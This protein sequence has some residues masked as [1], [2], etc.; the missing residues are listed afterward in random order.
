MSERLQVL[1]ESVEHLGDVAS[2]ITPSD[3]TAAAYPSEW[4]IADTF[5]HLGSGA[6]IGER[7]FEDSI[8]ERESDPAFN[9]SVWDEWNAK[10]PQAQVK[11]A[12]ASD[13]AFLSA[14][15]AASEEQRESFH[16][17]MGPFAF[18]FEGLVGLRLSEHALHTWDV[19]VTLNPDAT[20]PNN[21][22]NAILDGIQFIVARTGKA[23]S[24]AKDV[25]VRTIEPARDF[26]LVL[27]VD[28]VDIV[29][30]RHEGAADLEIP[31]EAF[32]RLIYGRL[33][34]EHTPA[35]VTGDV[36]NSLRTVFP[37]F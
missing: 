37:G 8:A 27:G 6:V 36:V 23:T 3:Y 25:T 22:A 20:V 28:S 15:E 21:T 10:D 12:L 29:E 19:E 11:D 34:T 26:T 33:D 18:D 2:R 9:T 7:R 30:A 32:V 1:R 31:A 13:A 35:A 4:S 24:E 5:S 16:F 17:M 14:L